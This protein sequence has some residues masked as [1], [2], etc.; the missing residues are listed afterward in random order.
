M[1]QIINSNVNIT[2]INEVPMWNTYEKFF[3][4]IRI[5]FNDQ[6]IEEINED[7]FNINYNLYSDEN[8]KNQINKLCKIFKIN[9][10]YEL[11][12]PLIFW[13]SNKS[14]LALPILA[15]PYI[16]IKLNFKLNDIKNII[17]N[18]LSTSFI[19]S[20]NTIPNIKIDLISDIII[21]NNNERNL[22]GSY[23]HEYIISRYISY[24][25]SIINNYNSSIDKKFSG[26][27][28]D[29]FLIIKDINNKEF[30]KNIYDSKYNIY[31]IA[32]NY[33]NIYKS[34][35]NIYTS[36]DQL[37]YI[38][39]I[40]II[41][42]NKIEFNN[43]SDRVTYLLK[44]LSNYDIMFLLYYLDKYLSHIT[45]F[46]NQIKLLIYYLK[47]NFKIDKEIISPLNNIL[48]KINGTD[49]FSVQPDKYYNTLIPYEKFK[50]TIPPY[51]YVY[52]FSLDPLTDQPSGHL[53]FTH[54]ED[55]SIILTS[56]KNSY[57]V[58]II[59]KEY[60]ILRIVSGMGS[61]GWIN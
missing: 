45:Q 49:L 24:S 36:D 15:L 30:Y 50:T 17:N 11:Y 35:N 54:F 42:N 9:N 14:T 19:F 60:N 56:I 34:N 31:L 39:D 23:N 25:S 41:I 38:F 5:Y 46:N 3:E 47:N 7:V 37:D 8:K 32:L 26:L 61:L 57:K 48:F 29:I 22:F 12:I 59:S 51:I 43:L 28:K 55:T 4:Y 13:F 44:L 1:E 16:D 2:Y 33:Y 40:Q 10:F 18:D 53:N 58:N 27:I 52:S 20:T 6:L 21:L